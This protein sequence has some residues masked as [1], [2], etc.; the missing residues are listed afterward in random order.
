L[1]FILHKTV[2]F[3]TALKMSKKNKHRGEV[4]RDVILQS[5][6]SK[7][8]IAKKA[9]YSR[10]SVYIHIANPELPAQILQDYGRVLR[11]DFSEDFPEIAWK[12]AEESPELNDLP[13]TIEEAIRQSDLWRN[14]YYALLEKYQKLLEEKINKS[15]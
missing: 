15:F 3:F 9:G 5:N 2:Y 13:E 4:L 8:T 1:C 12:L 6:M 14:K 10:G 7:T 11:H